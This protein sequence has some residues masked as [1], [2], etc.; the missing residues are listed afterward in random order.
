MLSSRPVQL[1][2]DGSYFPAKTP[3]RGLANRIENAHAGA[4]TMNPKGKN[5]N[6]VPRTPFQP[7]SVQ[8]QRLFKD[9]KPILATSR[10]LVDKTPLPNRTFLFQTPGPQKANLKPSKLALV[11]Q[12]VVNLTTNDDGTPDSVQRPSSMRKHIKQPRGSIKSFE[13]PMNQGNHWDVSDG[14]IV[15]PSDM[16][17]VVQETILEDDDFDE[18]EYMAPNTLDLPYQPPFDFELPDY[19]VVGKTLRDLA[20]SCP[21]DDSPSPVDLEF[22][23]SDLEK[24]TWDMLTLPPLDLDDDP[25]HQARLESKLAA[26]KTLRNTRLATKPRPQS[27]LARLPA[28]RAVPVSMTRTTPKPTIAT[29]RALSV[30]S[31][32]PSRPGTSASVS[33][34]TS[35]KKALAP[36][37]EVKATVRAAKSIQPERVITSSSTKPVNRI[38]TTT[39]VPGSRSTTVGPSTVRRAHTAMALGV[40]KTLKKG[41]A[42]PK[43]LKEN[44][45]FVQ[46]AGVDSLLGEEGDFLFAV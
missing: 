15:L 24:T 35:Q 4:M 12:G 25:F 34:V 21:Y 30:A 44:L 33:T 27:S 40:S 7:S 17:A 6:A 39:T 11:D 38:T 31:N 20:Y 2:T 18:I 22:A 19:K 28:S 42:K 32:K 36:M 41:D 43:L 13:T 8:P 3:G 10:L 16:Q 46:D 26:A 14:D 1:T 23:V 37:T 5:A 29:Q 9:Q 45:I